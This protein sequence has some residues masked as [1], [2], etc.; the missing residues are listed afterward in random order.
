MRRMAARRTTSFD[1][2]R[3]L[4]NSLASR[5]PV[6]AAPE[7]RRLL[8]D[9]NGYLVGEAARVAQ[10]LDLRDLIQDMAAAFERLIAEGAAA[11]KGCLGK[12]HI[13]EALLAF[14]ADVPRA[15]LAGLHHVQ[16]EPAFPEA[17]DTAGPI[18]GLSAHALVQIDHPAA[19]LEIAPLLA[20]PEPM[21]RA[22]GARALSRSGIEA[23]AAVLHLAALRGDDEIDVVQ[24]CFEG[25]LRLGPDRYLPVVAAALAEGKHV[26]AAALA[27]GESRSP[28]AFSVLRRA[29]D[30]V[31][32][33]REREAVL[34]GMALCRG[35]EATGFLLA[36]I[37]SA[38]EGEAASALGAL[39]IHR[40]DEAL[41]ARVRAAVAARKSRR[42][43]EILGDRFGG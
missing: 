16:R 21:V 9:K 24:A 13:L 40:H 32:T 39:S 41:A 34:M 36:Q 30:E 17:I 8:A 33:P 20:D 43:T 7:L 26:E 1:D 38:P 28:Q 11:D 19:L 18:R 27:I 42:L 4:I 6:E 25:L 12:R 35:D 3:A 5:S 2:K 31:T 22:E 15:Y 10:E 29:L 14:D 23:A 37:T